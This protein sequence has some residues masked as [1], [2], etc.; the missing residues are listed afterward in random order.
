MSLAKFFDNPSDEDIIPGVN[1]IDLS[2]IVVSTI[3]ASFT[4]QDNVDLNFV[5]HVILNSIRY[6]ALNNKTLYPKI[7]IAVD[8]NANGYWRRQKS[9]FYKKHREK[10]RAESDWDWSSI[11]ESMRT[12][13]KELA[14][15]LPYHV[16]D[17]PSTEAD[18]VIGVL[19]HHINETSPKTPILVTSSDGDFTQLQKFKNVKQWS[20]MHKKFV[21]PKHGSGRNDLLTK[22]VKGDAKDTIANI[23]SPADFIITKVD[24]ARQASISSKLLAAVYDSKDPK[25]LFTGD[26]LKRFEE[27]ELMLDLSLV[28]DTI[29]QPIINQFENVKPAGR[30]KVYPY[31]IKHKL[32]K[33][34]EVASE[35]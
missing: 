17:L 1:L 22:I 15:N 35:F 5:R 29:K 24:G 26:E 8:N 12:V 3:T 6:N 23:K 2:Q 30:S 13:A 34:L 33:L 9:Y 27:N 18:D 25:S 20:P 11:H 4:P 28:P 32:V 10:I 21:K 14:E 16:I 19:V 7:V 31:L